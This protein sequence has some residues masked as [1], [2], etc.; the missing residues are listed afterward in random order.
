[1]TIHNDP[2]LAGL[3]PALKNDPRNAALCRHVA[4]LMLHKG[5]A[6]EAEALVRESIA[7]GAKEAD[8]LPVFLPALMANG[9]HAEAL[10]R[11]ETALESGDDNEVRLHYARLLLHKGEQRNALKEYLKVK[12]RAPR[13][14]DAELEALCGGLS[15]D[16]ARPENSEPAE[17][18]ALALAGGEQDRLDDDEWAAQF[19]WGDLKVTFDDVAGLEDVK[20]QIHLRIIAPFKQPEVYRAFRRSGGGGILLYGPPGCG[21]TFL[22]RAAAGECGA[23]FISVGISEI[24]DKYWGESEKLMHALFE[25]ARRKTPSVIFFDEFDALGS[26]RGRSE[27]QFWKTLVDQ[28]LQEMDGF[29]ARNEDVLVFAAT[30]VPWNVDSAFRR[31]GRFDR[32]FF[33]P[34]PDAAARAAILS[35]S[36]ENLPG[37]DGIRTDLIAQQTPLFTGA[38]LK[39]LC[40]RAADRALQE[41]LRGGGVQPI[42]MADFER[43][44]KQMQSTAMEWISTAR[45]Y[46]KYSNTGGQYDDLTNFL[47]AVKKW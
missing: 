9:K 44:L 34:P 22:A 39:S 6:G 16:A 36:L 47:K 32:V 20:N 21:K 24:V 46:A 18:P 19:D 29:A 8:L 25:D 2:L 14:A 11:A 30:N 23:R 4:E 41:S 1:M 33:V 12:D 3:L 31:P 28:L 43:E 10:L 38:D 17:N 42:T 45:N 13:T 5:F 7:A 40:E 35:R 26:S 37:A 15:V 27:S